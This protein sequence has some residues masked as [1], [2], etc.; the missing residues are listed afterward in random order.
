MTYKLFLVPIA[1]VVILLS[2]VL[3]QDSAGPSGTLAPPPP[4]AREAAP[5]TVRIGYLRPD[6]SVSNS[7]ELRHFYGQH[8]TELAK[9]LDW[10]YEFVE[11]TPQE[12]IERLRQKDI[13]L[14]VPMEV[15]PQRQDDLAYSQHNFFLDTLAL[16]TREGEKRFHSRDL[17]NLDGA[18]VGLYANRPVNEVFL[19]FC[20]ENDL[21]PQLHVYQDQNEVLKA[22]HEKEIDLVLDSATNIRDG[23][24]FLTAFDLLPTNIAALKENKH[25]LDDLDRADTLLWQENPEYVQ[26][27]RAQ[28]R[29]FMRPMITTYTPEESTY[30]RQSPPLKV[31][32]FGE[33]PPY[34]EYTQSLGE[35]RGIYPDL[36]R[37]LASVSGFSFTFAHYNT[38]EAATES[39]KSGQADL[40][41]DSYSAHIRDYSSFSYTNLLVTQE[42]TFIGPT[43]AD[44]SKLTSEPHRLALV[45]HQS[46]AGLVYLQNELI[47]WE[48]YQYD[49]I[50]DCF[51]AVKHG[52]ADYA[53]IDTLKLQSERTLLMYP[54]LMAVPTSY[55]EI[56]VCL[57][58]SKNLPPILKTALNK[59]ILRIT[60]A[61][62]NQLVR[63]KSLEARPSFSLYYLFTHYPI[64][65]GFAVGILLLLISTLIFTVHHNRQEKRQRQI[66][67]QANKEMEATLQELRKTEK[68][69]DA[70]KEQAETDALTGVLNKAAVEKYVKKNLAALSTQEKV[71]DAFIIIDLDHFKE[72]NDTQG[73]Q[74]GDDILKDFAHALIRLTRHH[75]IVG[76]FGGDEF[77]LYLR[78]IPEDALHAFAQRLLSAAHQ[79]DPVQKPPLSASIGIALI[80]HSGLAYEEVFYRADKALY[81]VKE[82]G[83]DG[84]RIYGK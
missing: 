64:Q 75:D 42:M 47:D 25:F 22:L 59:T 18:S 76:R 40:I 83:R 30:I 12:A 34:V 32:F 81:A 70:Y 73:H 11:V 72:A 53:L 26:K 14:L 33:M 46:P 5:V 17:S 55:L 15:N 71:S 78:N 61:E 62:V 9:Y 38:Y 56:P 13:D 35:V 80:N 68:S 21:K 8:L 27:I 41:I 65:S 28:F 51:E 23:E 48:F 7:I 45:R 6:P 54:T 1:A 66:L 36:F 24:S 29:A 16:Y 79:L 4:A 2:T 77:V 60:V 69:R 10:T 52:Q 31:A 3:W 57:V 50:S 49:D 44:F 39:L 84:Y 20:R 67:T 82:G 19:D 74:Y 43:S 63:S 58:I 37:L